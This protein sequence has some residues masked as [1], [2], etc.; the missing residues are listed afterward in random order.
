MEELVIFRLPQIQKQKLS[1]ALPSLSTYS[2]AEL[3]SR[4]GDC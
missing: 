3:V 2:D 1:I 4:V